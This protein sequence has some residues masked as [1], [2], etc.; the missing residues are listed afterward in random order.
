MDDWYLKRLGH[1]NLKT[2]LNISLGKQKTLTIG[3]KEGG[4]VDIVCDGKFVSLKHCILK[5]INNSWTIEDLESKHGVYLNG[6]K[7]VPNTQTILSERD[8]IGVGAIEAAEP[9]NFVFNVLKNTVKDKKGTSKKSGDLAVVEVGI[10]SVSEAHM[11]PK[12]N[13]D[14]NINLAMSNPKPSRPSLDN[15]KLKLDCK[16][17]V[18]LAQP[19]LKSK[20]IASPHAKKSLSGLKSKGKELKKGE[21]SVCKVLKSVL[22]TPISEAQIKNLAEDTD[23]CAIIWSSGEKETVSVPTHF[24]QEPLESPVQKLAEDQPFR[25]KRKFGIDSLPDNECKKPRS[26]SDST[27]SRANVVSVNEAITSGKSNDE[28]IPQPLLGN[29]LTRNRRS[30]V[31]PKTPYYPVDKRALTNDLLHRVLRWSFDWIE[32]QKRHENKDE[33]PPL[34]D[35]LQVTNSKSLPKLSLLPVVSDYATLEDYCSIFTPLMLHEVWAGLCKD[36]HTSKLK[37]LETLIYSKTISDDFALL[38]CEALS[39]TRI[40]E[41]ELV[42][43][44][45]ASPQKPPVEI[46][47]VAEQVR[48]WWKRER[49]EIDP[50]LLAICQRPNIPITS[51]NLRIKMYH[52]LPQLNQV[53]TVTKITRLKTA[54]K[55]FILNAELAR[56]PLC[57]AIIQPSDHVDAF[58]LETVNQENHTVLN[59]SQFKAVESIAQT[60]VY[61]SDK[62]P[63][64][65]L[66]HGPPGTG[67]SRVTV[68]MI[69]R[70]MSLYH[71]KTGKQP[72]ILVCAP[73][74]HAIDELAT[75]LMDARDWG[76][77]IV[78][79]GVSES[80]RPEVRNISL[81]NL[82]R[83]IQQDAPTTRI[84][85]ESRK[86]GML[87]RELNFLQQKKDNLVAAIRLATELELLDEARMH[88]RKLQQL[89]V[90]IDQVGRCRQECYENHVNYFHTEKE[91]FETRRSLLFNAQIICSTIN[92]CRSEEMENLFLEETPDN[93]F[94]CCIIDEASQ[95]TEPESL[96][97]LA[98]GI[99]KLVL[100]GDPDQLPATVMSTFAQKK[101]FDQ[102]LFNRL[103]ASRLLV[104]QESEGVIMLNTQYRMASS[105][106]EWPS[107]Y[108]Y[109]G[110]IVTAEGL[111]RNGPCYD[112]RVL[113]VTDGIEQLEEQ[114]FKNEKEAVVVANIVKLILNSPLTVGK[115]VGVITFYQ[116]QKK[117]I[118]EKLRE[119]GCR[120][121][122]IDLN[123]VDSFQGRETDIVVI[124]CVRAQQLKKLDSIGFIRSLQWMNVAMTRAKESLI[125]CGHFETLQKNETC[126]DLI[127]NARSRNLAHV[128]S[129][130]S[131]SYDICPMIMRPP[132]SPVQQQRMVSTFS[133]EHG[134]N[135]TW[136]LKCLEET[137][138]DLLRATFSF[139]KFKAESK[140]PPEAF[141]TQQQLQKV[142]CF[143]FESSMNM[144]WSLK[145]LKENDWDYDRA[146]FNFAKFKASNEIPPEAF[147][148]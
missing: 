108:F 57:N 91:R 97:P 131:S 47:A 4:T 6:N 2:N 127:N 121:S 148:K 17:V 130:N 18:K 19:K 128:V 132:Y 135:T 58:K 143:S 138:W 115:S 68:E 30:P 119:V 79:I 134:M 9:A 125:L 62:Q 44:T 80:M 27:H 101:R 41:M 145:C 92:S 110:K 42:S 64:I 54:M 26:E 59:A 93:R 109:G 123:T 106:C 104:N 13:D 120:A 122:K 113:D 51:F 11:T 67:K 31:Q 63:K 142:D 73:S 16:A 40:F 105:I 35:A 137:E 8:V 21:R 107:R 141:I 147:L 139:T 3:K 12:R 74:N 39:P 90:Q 10:P 36:V 48:Y 77:R 116:S 87:S 32:E 100:I 118:S 72:R 70:M 99:S 22:V 89:V 71:K 114:S 34:L 66:V 38:Q 60:V 14:A 1:H 20:N 65:S 33:P 86:L 69:L 15:A 75:R 7:I 28:I 78:R 43:L 111:K 83:K 23:D 5:F 102:S 144:F 95:C 85:P 133:Q 126:Q 96:T 49:G 117:C 53:F 136:T 55:Q 103:H 146:A 81:D 52:V 56:S 61:S 37:T 84:S 140:I 76:S 112:Y 46:F 88:D 25:L 82:T 24:K 45:V 98:F 129:S 124:S 29:P 50:R 94:L